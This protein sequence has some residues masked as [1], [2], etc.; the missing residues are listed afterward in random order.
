LE[1]GHIKNILVE[2]SNY[3]KVNIYLK[4]FGYSLIKKLSV[5]DYLFTKRNQ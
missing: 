4:N 3:E 2:T 1:K 5:H